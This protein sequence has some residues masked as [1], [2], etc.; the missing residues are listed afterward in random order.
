M[1]IIKLKE[2]LRQILEGGASV[3]VSFDLGDV[4]ENLIWIFIDGKMAKNYFT[5]D[6]ANSLNSYL[7]NLIELPEPTSHF[8][9]EGSGKIVILGNNIVI[10]YQTNLI[11]IWEENESDPEFG[12]NYVET[13]QILEKY[14]DERIL[15]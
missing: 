1:E 3:E 6:F 9:Y 2:E 5:N 14:T 15:F 8:D 4:I 13:F 7:L 10:N 12:G 11:G